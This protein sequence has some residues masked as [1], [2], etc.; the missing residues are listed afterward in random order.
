VALL[1]RGDCYRFEG[2]VKEALDTYT[3]GV[4]ADPKQANRNQLDL[5]LARAECLLYYSEGL[6]REQRPTPKILIEAT[7]PALGLTKT[8]GRGDPRA[9]ASRAV[10]AGNAGMARNAALILGSLTEKEEKA[11]RDKAIELLREAIELDRKLPADLRPQYGW[12]WRVALAQQLAPSYR[13]AP[14]Q[15]KKE[16]ILRVLREARKTAPAGYTKQIDSYIQALG[17]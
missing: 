12:Q 2:K 6:L 13:A 8:S 1:F 4:P 7:E 11:Y 15:E 16:E 10:A 17:G 5:L 3:K 9:W 14:T